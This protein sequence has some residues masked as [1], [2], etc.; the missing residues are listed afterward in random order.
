MPRQRWKAAALVVVGA[1]VMGIGGSRAQVG[2]PDVIYRLADTTD[3]TVFGNI[4]N[5]PQFVAN[6]TTLLSKYGP[7]RRL[8][9]CRTTGTA[10]WS[11]WQ[12]SFS[13]GTPRT[14]TL[15]FSY[16]HL[17]DGS[18]LALPP[19]ELDTWLVPS[20]AGS[21]AS[22]KELPV[23]I[24]DLVTFQFLGSVMSNPPAAI[25][26]PLDTHDIVALRLSYD[27]IDPVRVRLHLTYRKPDGSD[28][29]GKTVW[30]FSLGGGVFLG[31]TVE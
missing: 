28:A 30:A 22:L 27:P 26:D 31:T 25:V 16:A 13:F 19:D 8:T 3:L 15:R 17:Q 4:V 11:E 18:P 7:C 2:P 14:H 6:T 29:F 23:L 10:D 24:P 20:A 5:D 21:T 12:G 9:F 1:L